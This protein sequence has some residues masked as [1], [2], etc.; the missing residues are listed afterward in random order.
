MQSILRRLASISLILLV[1]VG[2]ARAGGSYVQTNLVSDIPG[3][4]AL[5]DL[6]LQDPRGIA[7]SSKSPFWISDQSSSVATLY[8]PLALASEDTSGERA[9]S[10]RRRD[11]VHSV[12][13][14][15]QGR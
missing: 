4:A 9:V 3:M 5:A 7:L 8:S 1:A 6:N 13:R 2:T 14:D 12:A 10:L 11:S 15:Q